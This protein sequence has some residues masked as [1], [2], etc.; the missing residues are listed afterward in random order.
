M[1]LSIVYNHHRAMLKI[2]L[3]PPSDCAKKSSERRRNVSW[4]R[5]WPRN[6]IKRALFVRR[7]M[8]NHRDWRRRLDRTMAEPF[9]S[10][11]L[12]VSFGAWPCCQ[13]CAVMQENFTNRMFRDVR[14]NRKTQQQLQALIHLF[15]H[16]TGCEFAL[17]CS[18]NPLWSTRFVV[19]AWNGLHMV[20]FIFY[21]A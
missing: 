18:P 3:P 17:E 5:G 9:L 2:C 11:K 15:Y 12:I 14:K 7:K 19:V 21:R 16:R 13:L 10:L 20:S 8:R 4:W 6:I 1:K